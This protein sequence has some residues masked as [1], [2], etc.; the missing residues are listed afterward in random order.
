[1]SE[2]LRKS[3]WFVALVV[4]TTWMA[5]GWLRY[6]PGER[7]RLF[8]TP[9]DKTPGL[10]ASRWKFLQ[11]ARDVLPEGAVVTIRAA[12]PEEEMDL[13]ML[14]ASVLD[15]QQVVPSRYYGVVNPDATRARWIAVYRCAAVPADVPVV[16]RMPDGCICERAE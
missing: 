1:M 11:Q 5:F 6:H 7:L 16:A 8:E 10:D 4:L 3:V 13:F 9:F 2:D 12:T 14:S 15:R